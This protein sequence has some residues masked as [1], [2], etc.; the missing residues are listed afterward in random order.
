MLGK[1]RA[2]TQFGGPTDGWCRAVSGRA[3]RGGRVTPG[4][5]E[6]AL[7]EA[8]RARFEAAGGGR[9]H[10]DLGI[11]DDAAAVTLPGPGRVVLATDLVV[12]GVHVDRAVSTPE[13]IGWKALMA[14]VSDIGAMGCAPSHALLS[15]AAPPGFPIERLGDGVAEAAAVAGCTVVGGDLSTSPVLVVSVTAVGVAG[16]D[17]THLLTR[18]GA[19]PGDRLF[20]TGPTGGSAAGL[21]LLSAAAAAVPPALSAAHR[22]PVARL[23][24]G[25]AARGAGASAAVDVSD[26][27]V[28][29]LVRLAE[30]SGVGLDLVVGD[31]VVAAGATREEALG[32]GEDYELVLATADPDALRVAFAAAGLRPPLAIGACTERSAGSVLDGGPLPPGGWRHEF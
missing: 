18:A 9:D 24:E 7:I 13:D 26:G 28:A 22:R 17:G 10:G 31:A 30:A 16:P 12:E 23:R 15:I 6:F 29:D 4:Q 21:R 1:S 19:R 20:V 11:G 5:D 25:V 3:H 2:H 27:L 14:A 8:L 32:G